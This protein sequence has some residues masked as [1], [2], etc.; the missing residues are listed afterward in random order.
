MPGDVIEPA[1]TLEE[2]SIVLDGQRPLAPGMPAPREIVAPLLLRCRAG[3]AA[4]V[5]VAQPGEGPPPELLERV[6]AALRDEGMTVRRMELREVGPRPVE[7][8]VAL[9]QREEGKPT[10]FSI[11]APSVPLREGLEVAALNLHRNSFARAGL[12]AIFWVPRGAMG[13]LRQRAVNF[14]DFRTRTV[15]VDCEGRVI[16]SEAESASAST[17]EDLSI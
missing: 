7:T 5:L 15:E 17:R 14:L 6:E 2:A 13:V 16:G 11:L 3:R 10:V 4:I 12:C 9:R 8:L 1:T